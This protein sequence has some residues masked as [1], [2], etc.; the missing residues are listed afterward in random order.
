MK[1][2]CLLNKEVSGFL[3]V[4][5]DWVNPYLRRICAAFGSLGDHKG[6]TSW[7]VPIFQYP[8]GFGLGKFGA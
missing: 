4:L 5:Y 8:A 7:E 6:T 2:L 3:P 1:E